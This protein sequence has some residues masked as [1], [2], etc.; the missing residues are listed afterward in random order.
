MD[1]GEGY[2][3]VLG[4]LERIDASPGQKVLA[5]EPVGSLGGAAPGAAGADG[6]ARA[7]L[8]VELRRRG[9]PVDPRPWFAARG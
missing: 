9:D 8:Y 2:H 5:G 3:F 4:G 6:T 1:C 7:T